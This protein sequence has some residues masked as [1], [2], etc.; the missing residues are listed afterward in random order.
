[1][2]ATPMSTTG[3]EERN[4]D[5]RSNDPRY[6][7]TPDIGGYFDD[8]GYDVPYEEPPGQEKK[9]PPKLPSFDFEAERSIIGSCMKDNS[10]VD[11]CKL[12][13]CDF[14]LAH[15]QLIWATI[16]ERHQMM[17]PFDA[18]IIYSDLQERDS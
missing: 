16:L 7:D 1:M 14:Y 11:G 9:E 18:R 2:R 6:E 13:P 17:S 10:K 15:H 12:R 4:G 5:S 3:T 8:G